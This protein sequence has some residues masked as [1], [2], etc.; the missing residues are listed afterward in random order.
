MMTL[1]VIK[2]LVGLALAALL[3]EAIIWV[4]RRLTRRRATLHAEDLPGWRSYVTLKPL[5][6]FTD[7]ARA[8]QAPYHTA[9]A[10]ELAERLRA[11][12][13]T[14]EGV[15]DVA[16]AQRLELSHQGQRWELTLGV[17]RKRPEQWLL[18][19]DQRFEHGT[20]APHDTPASRA[21]LSLLGEVLQG[22]DVSTVRWHKRQDWNRGK[23]DVWSYK[24]F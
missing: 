8:P 20:S 11:R 10:Q 16:S 9:M 19:L 7:T 24:P 2:V 14:I 22:M 13:V 3:S 6:R 18:T 21:M 5:P 15:R 23:I 1:L 17:F 12:G 4:L